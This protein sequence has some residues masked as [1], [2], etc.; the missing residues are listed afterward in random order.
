[1]IFKNIG[2]VML[3]GMIFAIVFKVLFDYGL[4]HVSKALPTF[5]EIIL[6]PIIIAKMV[7]T[8]VFGFVDRNVLGND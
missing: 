8:F 2:K 6:F 7:I 1:M 4:K 5:R 3:R